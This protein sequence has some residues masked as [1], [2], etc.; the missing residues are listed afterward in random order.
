MIQREQ[1]FSKRARLMSYGSGVNSRQDYVNGFLD[2]A[3]Y[4]ET[5]Q[6]VNVREYLPEQSERVTTRE[7]NTLTAPVL[8]YIDYGRGTTAL[9]ALRRQK[10]E[11]GWKWLCDDLPEEYIKLWLPTPI[12]PAGY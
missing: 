2:G 8:C 3:R 4:A 10:T 6:W 12:I 7:E 11:E 9:R 1:E 5:T